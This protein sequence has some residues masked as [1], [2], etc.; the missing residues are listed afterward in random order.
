M[1]SKGSS[2]GFNPKAQ[3]YQPKHS[4]NQ[5]EVDMIL[6]KPHGIDS[7]SYKKAENSFSQIN[8]SKEQIQKLL[9]FLND[10][11]S[12]PRHSSSSNPH[13]NQNHQALAAFAS[14]VSFPSTN[15][16]VHWIIDTSATNHIICDYHLFD[17]CYLV[18]NAY[19]NLQNGLRTPITHKGA[20]ILSQHLILTEVLLVPSF[21]YNLISISK[22]IQPR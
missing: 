17:D 11:S 2:K 7:D 18:A 15:N 16:F 20:V 1:Q 10:Q 5:V 22:L 14:I 4:A 6:E 12:N 8:L 21:S 9:V 19:V 13:M 3:H